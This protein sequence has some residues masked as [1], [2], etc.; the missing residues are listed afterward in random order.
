MKVRSLGREDPLEE[1]MATHS[2]ITQAS[3]LVPV[4]KKKP[5][6]QCRRHKRQGF[7]PWVGKIPWRKAWQPTPVVLPGESHGQR[8]LEIWTRLK[9]LSM[10]ACMFFE[11]L[12]EPT[13]LGSY[14]GLF[15]KESFY[16]PLADFEILYLIIKD[17]GFF[18]LLP[19]LLL[20]SRFSC[21]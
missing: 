1:G 20:R 3:Q 18:S 15:L 17:V 6:C 8:R 11:C 5:A 21:V 2:N 13:P 12:I 16:P 10:H 19:L 4:V 14:L 9:Q 7:D